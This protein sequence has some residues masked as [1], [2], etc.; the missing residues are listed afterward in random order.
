MQ[1]LTLENARK[2]IRRELQMRRKVWKRIPG[3]DDRFVNPEHQ[4]RYDI[5]KDTLILLEGINNVEL[6]M[7][8]ERFN[9]KKV[10]QSKLF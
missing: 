3:K 1:N 9:A 8:K 10:K 5:L 4:N 7:F 2:E 6:H